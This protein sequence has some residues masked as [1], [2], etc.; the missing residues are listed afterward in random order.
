MFKSN[1]IMSQN[2]TFIKILEK[3]QSI[4]SKKGDFMGS[5]AAQRAVDALI[6]YNK[7]IE[8]PEELKAIKNV[9]ASTVAKYKEFM[10]T[11]TLKFIENFKNDP[12]N[13]FTN[14]YGIGPKKAA[15][16]VNDD[17]VTTIS[18]LR[19]HQDHLLNDVQ[20]KGLQ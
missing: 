12:I 7:E 16:L 11:G 3:V 20:K 13:L 6:L 2:A 18:E 1:T 15:Q 9:G 5:K 17:Q 10:K 8:T 19:E 4:K 14:V